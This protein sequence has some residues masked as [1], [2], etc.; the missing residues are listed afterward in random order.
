MTPPEVNSSG[1]SYS[2]PRFE[3]LTRDTVEHSKDVIFIVNSELRIKYCNPAWDEFALANGG[4]DAAAACVLES[5]LMRVI[6]EPLHAF[7]SEV[8]LRC[9]QVHLAFHLDYECSS[10]QLY[11]LRHMDILPLKRSGEL[12][13][14]NSIR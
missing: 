9:R 3:E 1:M 5:D 7:Y 10:A 6:P 4:E 2:E 13:I 12:A 14:V 8:F 11:R